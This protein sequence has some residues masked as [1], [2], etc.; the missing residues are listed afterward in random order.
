MYAAFTYGEVNYVGNR[1]VKQSIR[2]A[3]RQVFT[4]DTGTRLFYYDNLRRFFT[5][6]TETR[7]FP[8]DTETRVFRPE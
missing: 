5:K 8:L 6:D 1:G 2:K 3:E 7:T 4:I